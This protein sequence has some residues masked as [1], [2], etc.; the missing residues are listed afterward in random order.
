[1]CASEHSRGI[2]VPDAPKH[3]SG[4]AVEG[5]ASQPAHITVLKRFLRAVPRV[6]SSETMRYI[7][8]WFFLSVAIGI[9]AGIGAI[10]RAPLGGAVLAAGILYLHDVEVEAVIPALIAAIVGYTI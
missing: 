8:R 9:V 3:S 10:F 1:M 5:L 7:T 2:M 6:S 4:E